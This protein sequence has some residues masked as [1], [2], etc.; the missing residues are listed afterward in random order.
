MTTGQWG[1]ATSA[2]NGT[3]L[4]QQAVSEGLRDRF[5]LFDRSLPNG[6][7]ILVAQENELLESI[8][9]IDRLVT[10]MRKG[11]Q[12]RLTIKSQ[13]TPHR[14]FI[15]LTPDVLLIRA[16]L[17]LD[18]KQI[19]RT[20]DHHAI[21][22]VLETVIDHSTMLPEHAA[23]LS[24]EW[25]AIG[26]PIQVIHEINEVLTS[27]NSALSDDN[28]RS[29]ERNF[30]RASQKDLGSLDTYNASLVHRHQSLQ[31]VR[32]DLGYRGVTNPI[33]RTSFEEVHQSARK[34]FNKLIARLKHDFHMSMPGHIRKI[35]Y[36]SGAGYHYHCLFFFTSTPG[37]DIHDIGERIG[38]HWCV[39]ATQ[40][41]GAYFDWSRLTRAGSRKDAHCAV[42]GPDLHVAFQYLTRLDRYLRLSIGRGHTLIKGKQM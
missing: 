36:S 7:R 37:L 26:L 21:N 41:R 9:W 28:L 12:V 14:N 39:S 1:R 5:F 18:R 25:L 30:L 20:F 3:S 23:F 27:L 38:E 11:W 40:G 19:R 2:G 15:Q 13:E 17:H 33:S 6:P 10:R 29:R 16:W 22:P 24:N 31:C 4:L 32:I 8:G 34:H 35:E 42:N